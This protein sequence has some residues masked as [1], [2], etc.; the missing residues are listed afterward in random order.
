MSNNSPR[1]PTATEP[2]R[3]LW[4]KTGPLHPLDTGGKIRTYH[5]LRALRREHHIT[6]LALCPPTTSEEVK[7]R[8]SEYSHRQLWIPWRETPRASVAFALELLANLLFSR[9][10]YVIEKYRSGP[11]AA[12]IRQ[13]TATGEHDLVVCDFLTPA[14]NLFADN[15]RPRRAALLFQHNV[16]SRIW[17][18][19]FENATG[20]RRAYFRLQWQRLERFERDTCARFDAVVGVSEEDC[21]VFRREFGL[22]NVLGAVPTGVDCEFFQP[23]DA[24]RRPRS[25]V[26][27]GSMDWMPNIEAVMFFVAEVWPSLRR[28]F[29]DAT[30][31]VVG[32]N[33]PPAVRALETSLPGV[34]VTGT[35]PDV[36]PWL[37]EAA[38]MVVP[39]RVGSG[40]RLKIFEAMATGI[41]VVSTRIGA[42]GLPVTDGENILLADAPSAIAA[43]VAALFNEPDR[44]A[45][46]GMAGRQLVQTRFGWETAAGVFADYCRVACARAASPPRR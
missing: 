33:P 44:A 16:E 37:A 25:L 29:P 21:D 28:Q 30:F 38:V 9:R 20:L 39:L 45:R 23:P 1:S 46:I 26:F 11:M 35:V 13:I 4:L 18:R 31:T 27:L 2:L 3:L 5:M 36:R 6:F 14:V 24:P 32:R 7:H 40:T 34:R 15:T 17:R 12:A 42:E 8:A 10:P 22:R 41:P 19:L 43:A